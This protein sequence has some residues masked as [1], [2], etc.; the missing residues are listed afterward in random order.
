MHHTP[1]IATIVA[2]LVIAFVMGAI[3]HRLRVSP[4]AGYLL[5]GVMVGP[6]TPG[7]VADANLASE[8]AEI[9]VIL[10]M[11][12]V[13]LHFSLK[14]LLA[15]RKVAIPGAIGQISAATLMG[16][17]LAWWMGW[18]PLAGFVFGLALSVASTVVLL[19]ALQGANLVQT[20]RGRIA[21]GWL[22]VEDLVMVFALVLLPALAGAMASAEGANFAALA[23]PIAGTV[24]KVAGFVVLMLLVGRRVIPWALQWVVDS[25]SRE[26]FRLAVLAIALG[27]AFGAAFVFDVSFALGAFFAG[28]ILGET[29]LSRQA[30]EE[31][32]P[33][34]DAFAVLFFVSVGMLFDPKVL[35]EQP[36]PLLVTVAIILVG[37][38]LAAY[39]IV[40]ALKHN[41]RTAITAA[42]SL[43]QI[44]EFSF[45]LAT[46]GT[47]LNILPP[48]GRDLI[49]A[50]AIL[51]IFANPFLFTLLVPKRQEKPEAA[52]AP[53]P[54]DQHG[55]VVLIGYGRVG[56]LIAGDLKAAGQN[57]VLIEDQSDIAREAEEAGIELVRGNALDA[58]TLAAANIGAAS[59]LLI[60][61][62]EGFEAGAIAKKVRELNVGLR[63]IARAHSDAEVAHLRKIGVPE[64]VM[65][66]REIASRMLALC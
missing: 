14:D 66:E 36:V 62:P 41:G 8:L 55:H 16:M 6:F 21:V 31:T 60:A 33:L 23:A 19:R 17:A 49:L 61:I 10:L 59:R 26:L 4:I 25:G 63:I 24:F 54:L 28:M 22:I 58:D 56:R 5:A 32:L 1:L 40:R 7:F 43:A 34:R 45:I 29:P 20:E 52:E 30:T 37:K 46:L 51:S 65:G 44:G 38:S 2:G 50:G 48:E 11:F 39:A 12:G 35:V 27:V 18:N 53:A 42:A 57:F 13:G 64:V 15:V 9:G 47:E 3:A